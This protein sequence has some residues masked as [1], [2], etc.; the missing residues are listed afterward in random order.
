MNRDYDWDL[1]I[2]GQA[3]NGG[4]N[5]GST[6]YSRRGSAFERVACRLG[7][8]RQPPVARRRAVYRGLGPTLQP[9]F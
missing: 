3:E 7:I 6:L 9:P 1:I 8:L 2:T 5:Q 4:I